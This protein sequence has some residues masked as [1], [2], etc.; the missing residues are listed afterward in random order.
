[1]RNYLCTFLLTL[2][3]NEL[4]INIINFSLYEEIFPSAFKQAIVHPQLK[5]PSLPDDDFNNFCPISNLNFI[6]KILEKVVASRISSLNY[7]QTPYL[8]HFNPSIARYIPLLGIHNDLILA[9]KRSEV[10][11]LILLDLSAACDT[12]DPSILLHCTS[13]D[14]FPSYLTSHSRA[15]SNQNSTSSSSNLSCGV[16]R[17]TV[18]DPLLYTLHT[19]PLGFGISKNSTKYHLY[20]D[21]TQLYISFTPSKSTT[22]LEILSNTVS[23]ILSW[24]NSNNLLLNPPNTEFLLVGT[25]QQRLKFSQLNWNKIQRMQNTHVVTNTLNLNT[26]HQYSRNYIGFQS[27]FKYL[28]E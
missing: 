5:K 19:T 3:F 27:K 17:G 23:Y 16:P 7:C 20:V 12:V 25:K 26:S 4:G 21:D 13:L 8:L 18:L 28:F 15:V 14:W 11:S 1:M 2:S 10:T 24:M 9:T 6:S 22:S